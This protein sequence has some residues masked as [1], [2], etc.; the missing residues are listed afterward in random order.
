MRRP[1]VAINATMFASPVWID[2][3]L[4]TDVGA[5]VIGDDR[6]RTVDKKLGLR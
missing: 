4:E 1:S 3:G 6:F 5:V 2:A